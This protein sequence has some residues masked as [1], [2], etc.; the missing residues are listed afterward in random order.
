M[1]S[2]FIVVVVT[3]LHEFVKIQNYVVNGAAL[4]FFSVCKLHLNKAAFYK[5]PVRCSSARL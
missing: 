1:F 5:L 2:I 3:E 4:F